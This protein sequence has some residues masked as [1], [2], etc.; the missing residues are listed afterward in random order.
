MIQVG[1]KILSSLA[2]TIERRMARWIVLHHDRVREDDIFTTREEFRLILGVRCSSVT[3]A[4]SRLEE[5]EIQSARDR[6]SDH[7]VGKRAASTRRA[8]FGLDSGMAGSREVA[9]A[10]E[11]VMGSCRSNP[12]V[13][14][15]PFAKY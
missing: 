6:V 4:L 7:S 13:L 14:S 1:R 12:G 2:Q 15:A 5:Q 10:T 11:P 8:G 3:D 9:E